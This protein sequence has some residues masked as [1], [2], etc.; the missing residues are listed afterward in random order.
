[1]E[2]CHDLTWRRILVEDRP[3]VCGFCEE[4]DP[5]CMDKVSYCKNDPGICR[6]ID[7]QYFVRVRASCKSF[8]NPL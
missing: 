2:Q 8:F 4:Q 6:D 7:L 1:M 5:N 3:A